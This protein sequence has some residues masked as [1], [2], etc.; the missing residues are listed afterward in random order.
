MAFSPN[1]VEIREKVEKVSAQRMR[2]WDALHD[3]IH[4]HGGAVVSVPGHKE[5]RIE[6]PKDS[7]LTAKL[8]EAGYDPRHCCTTTRITAGA[9][10]SVDVVSIMILGK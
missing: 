10:I 9:F 5:L 1:R 4:Q 6:V 7:A 3:Y 8:A 2:L